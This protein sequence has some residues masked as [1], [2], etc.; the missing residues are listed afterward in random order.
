MLGPLFR[1]ESN[2]RPE[3]RTAAECIERTV[4]VA[5]THPYFA[6]MAALPMIDL[7]ALPT[8]ARQIGE[9]CRRS[10][11]NTVEGRPSGLFFMS[12]NADG[13]ALMADWQGEYESVTVGPMTL[14]LR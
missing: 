7:S 10:E 12:Q 2:E 3:A 6:E 11:R 1:I 13:N 4:A 9:F 8:R 14:K 5:H